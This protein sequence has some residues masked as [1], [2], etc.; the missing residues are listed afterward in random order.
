MRCILKKHYKY[1]D[2]KFKW[3]GHLD[4][5]GEEAFTGESSLKH[6]FNFTLNNNFRKKQIFLMDND[7][8]KKEN[9]EKKG[10]SFLRVLPFN[11]NNKIVKGIE[12]LLNLDG[13]SLEKF[14]KKKLSDSGYGVKSI[15]MEFEKMKFCEEIC[16]MD[17]EKLKYIFKNIKIEIDKIL[18]I[19]KGDL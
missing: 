1:T 11:K 12:N 15:I 9:T 10:N 16:N 19:C 6:A 17:N 7:R 5:K 8:T 3:I 13:I 18:E 4:E 14:H 2:V